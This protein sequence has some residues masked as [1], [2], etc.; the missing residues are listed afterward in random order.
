MTLEGMLFSW[1]D[2]M[3]RFLLPCL[4]NQQYASR[5]GQASCGSMH[6]DTGYSGRAGDSTPG[7]QRQ[8]GTRAAPADTCVTGGLVGHTLPVEHPPCCSSHLGGQSVAGAL[9]VSC[10]FVCCCYIDCSV[11]CILCKLAILASRCLELHHRGRGRARECMCTHFA[12]RTYA[13]G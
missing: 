4:L 3:W 1:Q 13:H 11:L 7:Q 10:S 2:C 12:A 9:E 5:D 6:V 8:P